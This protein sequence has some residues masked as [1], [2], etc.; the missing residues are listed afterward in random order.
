[1]PVAIDTDVEFGLTFSRLPSTISSVYANL[2]Q[3]L[4]KMATGSIL[5]V[6]TIL[7]HIL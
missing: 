6:T 1:M 3:L 2:D 4:N 7:P 5:P